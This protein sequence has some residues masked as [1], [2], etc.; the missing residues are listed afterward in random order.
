MLYNRLEQL[1]GN[2]LL[3]RGDGND[4]HKYGY[5]ISFRFIIA[6]TSRLAFF[7]L[8]LLDFMEI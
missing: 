6:L 7:F 1:G 8:S 3:R 2:P 4:Q 5:F